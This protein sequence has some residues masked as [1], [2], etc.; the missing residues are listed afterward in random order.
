MIY[1]NLYIIS[2]QYKYIYIYI[3]IS[4]ISIQSARAYLCNVAYLHSHGAEDD[5]LH[6]ESS[7]QS[8]KY[9]TLQTPSP[10]YV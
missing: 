5:I 2:I 8:G 1:Y 6:L 7:G 3:Y 4:V 10:H 9:R